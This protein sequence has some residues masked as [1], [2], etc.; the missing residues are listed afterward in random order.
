MDCQIFINLFESLK[1][2][3]KKKYHSEKVSKYKHAATK[4]WSIMKGL[5]YSLSHQ[6]FPEELLSMKLIFLMSVKLQM[7]LTLSLQTSGANWQVKF[8]MLQEPSNPT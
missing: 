8:Q 6:T 4:T 7:N 3:A 1:K 5:V 2:K